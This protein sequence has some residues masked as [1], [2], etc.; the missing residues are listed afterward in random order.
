MQTE[1]NM[2]NASKRSE[3]PVGNN[4]LETRNAVQD[5]WNRQWAERFQQ[6]AL[7]PRWVLS[8][9]VTITDY[10]IAT[11]LQDSIN[12]IIAQNGLTSS[13]VVSLRPMR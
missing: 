10:E 1:S 3:A 9:Q 7:N 2:I 13:A 8:A 5:N 6:G 11:Q 12:S 4:T